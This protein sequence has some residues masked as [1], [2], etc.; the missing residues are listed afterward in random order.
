MLLR[1]I[2]ESSRSKEIHAVPLHMAWALDHKSMKSS[3]HVF[4]QIG[5]SRDQVIP[6]DKRY[7]YSFFSSASSKNIL[8][9]LEETADLC[10]PVFWT[11]PD[12]IRTDDKCR[13]Y[14]G[15]RAWTGDKAELLKCHL[16]RKYQ[17][18]FLSREDEFEI[19]IELTLNS[20]SSGDM[21]A[22]SVPEPSLKMIHRQCHLKWAMMANCVPLIY[23]N[24]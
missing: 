14:L 21:L 8:L 18:R 20:G 23:H 11:N 13:F 22:C 3:S 10:H 24:S 5:T 9:Q 17:L 2:K 16:W 6:A 7:L 12:S 15:S 19:W 1:L 4:R